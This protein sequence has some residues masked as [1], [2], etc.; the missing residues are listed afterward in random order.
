VAAEFAEVTELAGTEISTEQLERMVHRYQW[1]V[2]YCHDK[3]VVEVGCGSGQ[4]LGILGRV[5]G[6]LEGGDYS[7]QILSI[8]RAH[9]G[10]RVRLSVFDAQRLPFADDSKDVV[11]L[12]EAIYYVPDATRFVRECRR[13]LR[14]GGRVLIA[15]AN[16]DLADFNPSP[17]SH[18]YYGAVELADLFREAGF[19][20]ELY[21]HMPVSGVALRQQLL[22]PIKAL[23]V[24][25]GMMPKTMRGK[26]LLKRL[27][28]G[29]L[30]PMPAELPAS[31][32]EMVSPVPLPQD[33]ADRVHKVLY[34]CATLRAPRAV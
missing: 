32:A 26:K 30:V 27:V 5:A 25:L 6:T 9:Y 23:A 18:R 21:G 3:D 16:K 33:R 8:P 2:Q 31:P 7:S 4:G 20:V 13:V 22:R 11:I 15:T 14:S 34:C 12:F 29:R 1:A 24:N 19:E 28:F 10:E 17:L